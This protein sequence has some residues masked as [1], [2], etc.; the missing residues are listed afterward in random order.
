MAPSDDAQAV[1]AIE[2]IKCAEIVDL[3]AADLLNG[4]VVEIPAPHAAERKLVFVPGYQIKMQTGDMD[5][6][7]LKPIRPIP[8]HHGIHCHPHTH[9][10]SE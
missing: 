9:C 6:N 10:D 1:D 2:W 5:G 8:N 7:R 3:Y 4:V